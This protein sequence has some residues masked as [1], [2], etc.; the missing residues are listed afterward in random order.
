MSHT[1]VNRVAQIWLTSEMTDRVNGI[2][3]MANR[4][5]NTRPAIVLGAMLPYPER[6]LKTG[7]ERYTS[8]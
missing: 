4:M 6:K 1:V 5:Q 8:D 7:S 2:P 3:I